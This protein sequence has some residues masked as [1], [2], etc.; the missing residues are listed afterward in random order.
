MIN[1]GWNI[2]YIPYVNANPVFNEKESILKPNV[3][4]KQ[5]TL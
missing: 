3:I 2:I 4:A 5:Q 1:L